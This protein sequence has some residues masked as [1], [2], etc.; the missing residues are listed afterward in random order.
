MRSGIRAEQLG[1]GLTRDL[2]ITASGNYF[3]FDA[4]TGNVYLDFKDVEGDSFAVKREGEDIFKVE[5][6]GRVSVFKNLFV[7]G[8]VEF[9]GAQISGSTFTGTATN[10]LTASHLIEQ[11]VSYFK[12]IDTPLYVTGGLF[13]SS[14]GDWFLS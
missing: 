11:S 5:D 13:R 14:S 7:S 3:V 6:N 4:E 1:W 10:A 12:P 2:A 9:Q 8:S